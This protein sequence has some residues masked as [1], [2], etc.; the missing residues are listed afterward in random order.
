MKVRRSAIVCVVLGVSGLCLSLGG[1]SAGESG[2]DPEAYRTRTQGS[3][4][5]RSG[6]DFCWRAA[7]S[8]HDFRHGFAVA[9]LHE[10]SWLAGKADHQIE[11][12]FPGT[13]GPPDQMG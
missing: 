8:A 3:L 11:D 2:P 4:G 13:G 6:E 9:S 5:R 1:V 12:I 7:Y 10:K